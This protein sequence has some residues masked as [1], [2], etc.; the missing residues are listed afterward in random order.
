MINVFKFGGASVKN[1][2]AVKN[3]G[4]IINL[5]PTQKTVVV[6]SAMG[7]TTNAL[8]KL[9]D[10][11]YT[12]QPDIYQYWNEIK[13]YHQEITTALFPDSSLKDVPGVA[14]ILEQVE[15]Q[16]DAEP[17]DNFDYEYDQLVSV[18]EL[19]STR[20]VSHYL[21]TRGIN[22]VWLD[23]KKLIRTDSS[24][25][26]A[27]VNWNVSEEQITKAINPCFQDNN[28]VVLVQGFIGAT[29]TG[30][31]TT[32]GR[33]G[34]DFSAA[35]FAYCLDAK[36]VTIW[37]DVPGMLNADPKY[38][39]NTV[40]LPKIS[41]KEAIEL[42][43][44]GA[45]VIHPKTLKPLQNKGIPLY[46][47]SFLTPNSEGTIIQPGTESDHEVPSF[48]F[49][50]N[51]ILISINPRDFSFIMEENLSHIFN[52][53]HLFGVKINLMQ[54]SA[55][56]FSVSVDDDRR[57]IEPLLQTLQENYAIRYN[58]NLELVTIRHYNT[59]TIDRVTVNKEILVE[60]KSRY[61]ARM[62]MRDLG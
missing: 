1:A 14:P 18:G 59:E 48:I 8:E 10:A 3:V 32:L 52:L 43:Y 5:F 33:E 38:F 4:E 56:S 7:K 20:I 44:Y 42:S 49:R 25:R 58:R 27:K 40:R 13:N 36:A 12:H 39:D 46:V 11:W 60:Q 35:I 24:Y 47:K 9:L 19:L 61:T 57:K 54:N 15:K 22:S 51:Q 6:V 50:M 30:Q 34:S 17:S 29:D 62:V 37:K 53:F 26:E 2:D 23:A 21:N 45:T 41:F 55:L 31:T 16:L 28:R